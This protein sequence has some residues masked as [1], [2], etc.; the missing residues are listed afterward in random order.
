M[1]ISGWECHAYFLLF[2][3]IRGKGMH[4]EPIVLNLLPELDTTQLNKALKLLLLK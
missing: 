1:V 4:A 2:L 3:C